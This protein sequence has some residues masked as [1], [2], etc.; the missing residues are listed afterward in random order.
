M[1]KKIAPLHAIAHDSYNLQAQEKMRSL[2]F[3]SLSLA[4]TDGWTTSCVLAP[5]TSQLRGISK[6]LK[7][8]GHGEPASSTVLSR[9]VD[10]KIYKMMLAI[11]P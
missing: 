7:T 8:L 5:W 11:N 6:M 4:V 2:S 10:Y 9:D 3:L 1:V